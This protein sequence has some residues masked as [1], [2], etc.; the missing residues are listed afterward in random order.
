MK[1]RKTAEQKNIVL[2]H[3]YYRPVECEE[4]LE[5][6][7]A[8]YLHNNEICYDADSYWERKQ[9]TLRVFTANLKEIKVV[10]D[11]PSESYTVVGIG[12]NGKTYYLQL[13]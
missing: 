5:K 1:I 2:N 3:Y 6:N 12:V 7:E 13:N 4:L 8:F 9:P 11:K 10:Y